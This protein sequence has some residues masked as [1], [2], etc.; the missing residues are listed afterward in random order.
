[1]GTQ[2]NSPAQGTQ[3]K[4]RGLM[5]ALAGLGAA[6]LAKATVIDA[7][8]V[9]AQGSGQPLIIDGGNTGISVT[10]LTSN[11]SPGLKVQSNVGTGIEGRGAAGIAGFGTSGNGVFATSQSADAIFASSAGGHAL[12]VVAN[13]GALPAGKGI[14]AVSTNNEAIHCQSNSSI[15][16]TSVSGSNF[17]IYGFTDAG[18]GVRG[19]ATT[20]L[21]LAGQFVGA[22][23]VNGNIAIG[24]VATVNSNLSVGGNLVVTGT[25][26]AAV[27]D[28]NGNHRLVFCVEAPESWFQDF[29]S[30]T[31]PAGGRAIVQLK[32]DFADAVLTNDYHVILTE[33]G[34]QNSGLYVSQRGPT[35]FEV[36]ATSDKD[37]TRFGYMIV[38]KRRDV[39]EVR[40]PQ[41]SQDR[42]FPPPPSPLKDPPRPEII[43]IPASRPDG[44]V[45]GPR[46]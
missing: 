30:E 40:M 43:Q 27:P 9:Q 1:M 7:P 28:A 17:A 41:I 13:N 36:R 29:G 33:Y 5:A 23:S 12:N 11:G 6:A 19:E 37:A 20:N 10:S 24:G 2:D 4:R 14:V 22:V 15:S 45:I 42:L 16:L 18:V 21:G 35:S 34:S 8:R 38:A 46:R 25:K 39:A 44:P 26:S 3:V 31:L 32:R